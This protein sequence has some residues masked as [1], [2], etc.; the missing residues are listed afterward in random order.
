MNGQSPHGIMKPIRR[1][2]PQANSD[3]AAPAT[4]PLPLIDP[5]ED[6]AL[7]RVDPPF[8]ETGIEPG[9]GSDRSALPWEWP[10]QGST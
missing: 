7:L 6:K 2:D 5:P 10:L 8:A 4:E 9:W 3:A 1:L